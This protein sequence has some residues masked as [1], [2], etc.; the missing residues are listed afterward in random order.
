[1]KDLVREIARRFADFPEEISVVQI[2]GRHTL[3]IELRCNSKDLG[4]L[5]GR[6]GKTI[7]TIRALLHAL[8][9]KE[10]KRVIMEAVGRE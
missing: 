4:R 5:I 2:E 3:V 10:K 7:G 8:G 1:M 9:A 6:N